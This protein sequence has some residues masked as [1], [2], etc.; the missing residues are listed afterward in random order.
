MRIPKGTK[1][2]EGKNDESGLRIPHNSCGLSRAEGTIKF[3]C[4]DPADSPN[5]VGTKDLEAAGWKPWARYRGKCSTATSGGYISID[6]KTRIRPISGQINPSSEVHG[7][8]PARRGSVVPVRENSSTNSYGGNLERGR[9]HKA[10]RNTTRFAWGFDLGKL[11]HFWNSA[12]TGG[13]A[14]RL[15]LLSTESFSDHLLPTAILTIGLVFASSQR[16]QCGQPP[17]VIA[18][19]LEAPS[20]SIA[21]TYA[22]AIVVQAEEQGFAPL[23]RSSHASVALLGAWHKALSEMSPRADSSAKKIAIA[24]FAGFVEGRVGVALPTWWVDT[25]LNG[26]LAE[27]PVLYCPAKPLQ[28]PIAVFRF[29]ESAVGTG[30]RVREDEIVSDSSYDISLYPPHARLGRDEEG[31]SIMDGK[32]TVR[33]PSD[34]INRDKGGLRDMLTVK[35]GRAIYLGAGSHVPRPYRLYRLDGKTGR[36]DWQADV[37]AGGDLIEY[38]KNGFHC[39]A[40]CDSDDQVVIAGTGG[41]VF[42]LEAFDAETGA[43]RFRFSSLYGVVSKY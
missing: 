32:L 2:T 19:F 10:I 14:M 1:A 3:Y 6:G 11:P 36:I 12:R 24:R 39:A 33:V 40:I 20:S 13:I 8:A 34:A 28:T 17:D 4:K 31:W 5:N 42:Y 29:S 9:V 21:A 41:L 35:I 25:L 26:R 37:W 16:A 43:S 18:S 23:V 27:G 7:E 38:A 22:R 15:R 30:R